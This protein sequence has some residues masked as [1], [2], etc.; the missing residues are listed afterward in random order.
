M[1]D[2]K[3]APPEDPVTI[4]RDHLAMADARMTLALNA[5]DAGKWNASRAQL[6]M[7]AEHI[8]AA[9]AAARRIPR[10]GAA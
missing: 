4:A 8:Q 9:R 10:P 1:A 7:I 6:V 2:D 5:Y 3:P